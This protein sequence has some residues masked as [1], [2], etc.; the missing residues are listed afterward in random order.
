MTYEAIVQRVSSIQVTGRVAMI[1]ALI[2][3]TTI[4]GP[5]TRTNMEARERATIVF[6]PTG[7]KRPDE[8]AV[9][10]DQVLKVS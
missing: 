10:P 6:A 1:H 4:V 9:S 2:E 8:V 3:G 5:F 7:G